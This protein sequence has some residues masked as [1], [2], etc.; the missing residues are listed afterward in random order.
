MGQVIKIEAMLDPHTH[1]RDLE[2]AHKATFYTETSAAV[3]GGYWA[4]FDMPNTP[5]NT[6]DPDAFAI[7]RD[8]LTRQA[9]CDWGIYIGASQAD[10]TA[11]YDALWRDACGLKIFNNDTTGDLLIA[12]QSQRADHYRAWLTATHRQRPIAVHAE[13]STVLDILDLVREYRHPTHFLHISTAFEIEALRKAKEEGL[14]ITIGVCPHHLYLTRADEALLGAFGIMKPSLKTP[15]DR[16]AL[17]RAL[18]DGVV[19]II[20]SDHAPHTIAEKQTDTPPFGVTGLET[21]LPLM[22]TA[23][24]EGRLTLE[25]VIDLLAT[26]PRRIWDVTTP[27]DTYALVD[28]D[29]IYTLDNVQLH[30]QCGWSPFDGMRLHGRVLETWIR[31]TQVYDGERVCVEPGF[32]RNLFGD[33]T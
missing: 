7:K 25:R 14:P 6:I 26:N 4:V 15:A 31:G 24:A 21:N 9:V 18:A 13:E 5:P 29:A 1:L 11:H 3:A 27:P 30:T 16:D 2:W 33:A 22:L 12:D 19:D 32:G 23:V 17:W 8:A 28:I 20:E 10:N